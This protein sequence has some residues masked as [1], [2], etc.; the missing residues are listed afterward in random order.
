MS[1][2]VATLQPPSRTLMALEL[3]ALPE[4]GAFFSA[5]PLLS[6]TARGDGH[7]VLV[8]P[9][10]IASDMSTGPLRSFL[11]SKG[12]AAEGW[13]QGRNRGLRVGVEDKML[14]QVERMA[15]EHGRKVTLIGQ[16][17]GGIYAR[18]L[19]KQVPDLVRGVITLGSPFACPPYATNA[20]RVYEMASGMQVADAEAHLHHSGPL[21]EPPPV[22]TTSIFSR[23]DGVCAWQG[24]VDTPGPVVENIEVEGSHCGMSVHPAIVYAVADRLAQ[25]EGQWKP[26]HRRGWRSFVYPDP[27]RG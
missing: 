6:L 4:L 2:S 12:Y 5:L 7:P 22:P 17:L 26:F 1:A 3:R 24:C 10:L 20:W 15:D 27:A 8:L 16:S 21:S 11:Q 9:G 13:G 14:A 19:A 18:L 23:T 25:K